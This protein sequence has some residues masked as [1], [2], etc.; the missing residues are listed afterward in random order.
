[1]VKKKTKTDNE[2]D[3]QCKAALARVI[4]HIDK[5]VAKH[6]KE[7]GLAVQDSKK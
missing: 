2:L 3:K 4:K 5:M 7:M 6:L 1:V